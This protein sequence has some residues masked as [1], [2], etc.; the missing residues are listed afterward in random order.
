MG[1]SWIHDITLKRK[2]GSEETKPGCTAGARACPPED[3]GSVPGYYNLL[4][5]LSDPDHEEHESLMEWVGGKYDPNAFDATAVDR[6][7]KRLR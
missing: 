6:A 4:V 7:L 3:C 5:A 1:D 2:I